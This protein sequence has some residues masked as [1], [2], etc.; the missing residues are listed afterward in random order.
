MSEKL[1]VTT[2]LKQTWSEEETIFLGHWC[3]NQSNFEGLNKKN[4]E[5]SKYY[6]DDREKLVKDY[7]YINSLY[8]KIIPSFKSM[9]NKYHSV[10]FS[11]RY[12]KIIIGPWLITFLQIVFER[13]SNLSFFFSNK[14]I[15][16]L[17]TIILKIEKNQLTPKTYEEFTRLM[18]S[19]TWNHHIYS[20]LLEFDKFSFPV[21]KVYKN[22]ENEEKYQEYLI[23]RISLKNKIINN[24]TNIFS[25]QSVLIS[26]S[27]LGLKNEFFLA[28]NFLSFPR[29]PIGDVDIKNEINYQRHKI[30]LEFNSENFFE[31]FIKKNIL[32]FMPSSYLE[33]YSL[34]GKAVENMKWAK[35]P[36]IIFTSHFMTKTLQSRYTADCLEKNESKLVIG[37]H[38]GVY[39][40]YLF[41]S[42]QDFEID[43][44]DKYLTWGWHNTNEKI[45]P[46]GVIKNLKKNKYNP[47]N[48]NLLMIMRSQSRY[49][50]RL[51][52]YSGTNQIKKYYD[53]NIE[54][55]KNLNPKIKEEN[56]LLRFHARKFGWDEEKLFKNKL[57]KVRIDMGYEK[58]SK[59]LSS[60]KLVLHTYIGTGY[61][62]TLAS[63]IPT[64]IF[65]NTKECLLNEQTLI[66]LNALKETNI[67]HENY[68]SAV[69]FINSN[70]DNISSWWFSDTTQNV[71]KKFCEKYSKINLNKI[72]DLKKIFSSIN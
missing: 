66:D 65:A 5:I 24:F 12:W 55:C 47:N 43:I 46:F 68:S 50:H 20:L 40:Q 14:K 16:D 26:E 62:E 37:Q 58:I 9:L 29:Y 1:L 4:Y 57:K 48:E 49:T 22:F 7:K 53:E 70:W 3:E 18:L 6:W 34:V 15:K 36:K 69:K 21:K 45:I 59:L 11:E 32:N 42:M 31:E 28:L 39:G 17:Q 51:N 64:I 54:L 71:R 61:L 30:N 10:D 52:S 19:D 60:A 67:Y 13:Y 25:K 63:N 44:S 41:S 8:K 27:Y 2:S 35:R 23:K 72:R 33:K 56:L 38:G